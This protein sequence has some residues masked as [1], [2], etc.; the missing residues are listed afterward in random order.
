MGHCD[1]ANES[2]AWARPV[3]GKENAEGPEHEGRNPLSGT[4]GAGDEE[5]GRMRRKGG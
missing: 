3:E 5:E 4:G 1:E 2:A